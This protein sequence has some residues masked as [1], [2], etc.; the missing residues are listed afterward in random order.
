[1][2]SVN[3][4]VFVLISAVM[5][6]ISGISAT[7][8]AAFPELVNKEGKELVKKAVTFTS[9]TGT[10]ESVRGQRLT[11]SSDTGTGMVTSRRTAT[12]TVKFKGCD[13]FGNA[14]K[15]AGAAPGEIVVFTDLE[16]Q[17]ILNPSN[18]QFEPAWVIETGKVEITCS[19][20]ER[21]EV[22]GTAIATFTPVEK[23]ATSLSIKL[24][25]KKGVEEYTEYI[26]EKSEKI[27]ATL[28]TEGTG[29]VKFGPEEAGLE[30][31]ETMTFEE[32]VE[33]N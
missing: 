8:S 1:M 6:V 11:C 2:K 16:L 15:S 31:G 5:M 18:M 3:G 4:R 21:V 33:V 25:E 29:L 26:N 27:K 22:K 24:L 14:C 12:G 17:L 28:E 19:S 13:A 30:N 7:A 32:E 9:E 23:L 20:L 10:F